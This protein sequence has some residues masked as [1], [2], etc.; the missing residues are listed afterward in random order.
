MWD[1]DDPV[2]C[3]FQPGGYWDISPFL[4]LAGLSDKCKQDG[5]SW[6][7]A[8]VVHADVTKG[9]EEELGEQTYKGPDG[10]TRRVSKLYRGD[11]ALTDFETR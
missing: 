11:E 5:G 7:A 6:N 9:E 3:N 2:Y 4:K 1:S 8:F 10:I